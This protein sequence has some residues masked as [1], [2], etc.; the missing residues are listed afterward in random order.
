M[1]SFFN[2]CWLTVGLSF[3]KQSKYFDVYLIPCTKINSKQRIDQSTKPKILKFLEENM[4]DIMLSER[5]PKHNSKDRLH[6]KKLVSWTSTKWRMKLLERHY[7]RDS[8]DK[9]STH[10]EKF[11]ANYTSNK[12][13]IF[14]TYKK[15][16]QNS[17][18]FKN[19]QNIWIYSLPKKT[20]WWQINILKY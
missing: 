20:Y 3:C 2:K 10:W 12:R 4:G 18:I 7:L 14:N 6:E 16:F 9:T 5:F 15:N 19:E 17:K 13:F 11:F 8:K 1:D